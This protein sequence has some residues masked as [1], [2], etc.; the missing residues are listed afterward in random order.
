MPS[1]ASFLTSRLGD[2]IGHLGPIDVDVML[3]GDGPVVLD[4]NARTGGG[5]PF[6][7]SFC[8]QYVDAILQIALGGSHGPPGNRGRPYGHPARTR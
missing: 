7:A 2:A 6:T 4:I 5:F 8:P 3:T 1:E